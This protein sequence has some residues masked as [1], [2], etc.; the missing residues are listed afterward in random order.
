MAKKPVVNQEECT[1]CGL[2]VDLCPGVFQMND[3]EL[4]YVVDP[5]GA[6][7][8]EIQ[9]A[10]DQCPVACIIWEEE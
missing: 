8:E 1:S 6:S 4:A 2:C 3:D 10:M 7:E 9:D 5:S